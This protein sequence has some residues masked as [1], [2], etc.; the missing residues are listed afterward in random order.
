MCS[1]PIPNPSDLRRA[2]IAFYVNVPKQFGVAVVHRKKRT[3]VA[4]WGLG[5]SLANYPMALDDADRRLF[6]G[7]RLPARMVIL[8]IGSGRIVTA[9]PTVGDSDDI[10]YDSERRLI[11]VIGGEGAVEILRQRDPTNYD[12][13]GSSHRLVC[14]CVSPAVCGCSSSWIRVGQ[15]PNLPNRRR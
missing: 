3:A 8:D 10:F 4:K 12:R 6:V 13:A 1:V 15:N 7:C 2:G 9:L 5:G 11:Y 14:L